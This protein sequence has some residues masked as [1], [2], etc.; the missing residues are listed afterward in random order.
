MPNTDAF[1]H[2]I[3][4]GA[5]RQFGGLAV[6]PLFREPGPSVDYIVLDDALKSG[7]FWISEATDGGI[8][9]MLRAT[10][11]TDQPV[12]LMEGEELVGAKQNRV[13]NL[14]LMVPPGET[15]D[16][17]VSCVEAGRW[18]RRTELFQSSSN[19]QFAAGRARKVAQITDSLTMNLSAIS[20]QSD[21]WAAI[22]AKAERLGV[23]SG[24]SAMSAMFEH[25]IGPIDE[26]NDMLRAT[27][28]QIGSVFLIDGEVVGMD[29]FD[30]QTTYA[31]LHAKIVAGYAVDAL[32]VERLSTTV[33]RRLVDQFLDRVAMAPS[34]AFQVTGS[35][36]TIR[37]ASHSVAG[38]ALELNGNLVHLSAFARHGGSL[39]GNAS[40]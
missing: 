2:S 34:V 10:N 11:L 21:V 28:G 1:L 23:R 39:F 32:E 18:Q 37:L 29:A 24:T 22:D 20:D 33:S 25:H 5:I 27:P 14:S 35:G 36:M 26:Y 16:I 40:L 7:R 30:K 19:T 15:V 12:F 3:E 4:I 8:V 9:A 6:A 31:S 13:L 17:P 38:A